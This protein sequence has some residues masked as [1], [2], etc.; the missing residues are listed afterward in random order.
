MS[1][2]AEDFD[3]IEENYAL[4]SIRFSLDE[5]IDD[6]KADRLAR[7]LRSHHRAIKR[8]EQREQA[9]VAEIREWTARKVAIEQRS[10]DWMERA[11]EGFM[12]GTNAKTGQK[13]YDFPGGRLRLL[14]GRS[15]VEITDLDAL[16]LFAQGTYRPLVDW[17]PKPNKTL[18]KNAIEKDGEII[19]GVELIKSDEPNFSV[20]F[21]DESEDDSDE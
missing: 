15:K 6:F 19:P 18:I 17:Q 20:K 4:E 5:E 13:H 3:D 1:E 21:D 7:A 9:A 16:A 2:Q 12:R 10:I 11:L 14:A 8:L